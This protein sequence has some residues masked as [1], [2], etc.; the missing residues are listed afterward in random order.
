M[1]EQ[2]YV[3]LQIISNVAYNQLQ[4]FIASNSYTGLDPNFAVGCK[5]WI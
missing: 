5:I 1:V 3:I 4:F 2:G